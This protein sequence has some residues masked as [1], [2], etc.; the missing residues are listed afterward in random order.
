M[1]V[2]SFIQ[3]SFKKRKKE[4]SYSQN[5]FSHSF[6]LF[7]ARS[8]CGVNLISNSGIGT[9]AINEKNM[10]HRNLRIQKRQFLKIHKRT[11]EY[12]RHSTLHVINKACP[13]PAVICR[14]SSETT[15]KVRNVVVV[16]NHT[17]P[18]HSLPRRPFIVMGSC[19]TGDIFSPLVWRCQMASDWSN[20]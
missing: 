5:C 12:G 18:S 2:F 17:S 8:H 6:N 16:G 20:F 19:P 9:K 1:I 10:S 14:N 3:H 11:P 13:I 4:I 7:F 15:P